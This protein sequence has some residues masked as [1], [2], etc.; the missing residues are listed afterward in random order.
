MRKYVWVL[1]GVAHNN[2]NVK[3]SWNVYLSNFNDLHKRSFVRN[4]CN[5]Q[6]E[7]NKAV[8]VQ[9]FV[10]K[11]RGAVRQQSSCQQDWKSLPSSET[12]ISQN[13]SFSCEAA[14]QGLVRGMVRDKG[15]STKWCSERT[16]LPLGTKS[17]KILR[18]LEENDLNLKE[19]CGLLQPV[20]P[21]A[22]WNK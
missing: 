15:H 9:L 5:F 21:I 19:K 17:N 12:S 8:A 16:V 14:Q 22:N 2:E 4:N 20:R 7:I 13:E 1:P 10:R 11:G 6:C 18:A 3:E